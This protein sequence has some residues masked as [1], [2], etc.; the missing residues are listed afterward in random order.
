MVYYDELQIDVITGY[1]EE[2]R[3][4]FWGGHPREWIVETK[5]IDYEY[6]LSIKEYDEAIAYLKSKHDELK[7]VND[8][9][10]DLDDY[11]EELKPL[12]KERAIKDA[13]YENRDY[14]EK[15]MKYKEA[16]YD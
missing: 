7:N 1:I 6:N 3:Y 11:N 15:Q 13:E 14:F 10:I 5:T 9:D 4:G 8:N 2:E 12:F 16:E